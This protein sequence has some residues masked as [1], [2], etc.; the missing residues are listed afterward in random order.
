[1]RKV[2]YA[3]FG[4][5]RFGQSIVRTLVE[6]GQDVLACDI[7]KEVVNEVSTYA[8]HVIQIDV[9]EEA[10]LCAIGLSNFDVVLVCIGNLASAAMIILMAKEEGVEKV[11][12]KANSKREKVI[13][14]KIGADIV[15]LPEKEMGVRIATNLLNEHI[16]EAIDLS[17]RYCIAEIQPMVKWIGLSII[18]SNIRSVNKLNIVAIRRGDE[19]IVPPN[20]YEIINKYDIL[21]VVG[22]TDI[23]RKMKK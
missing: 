11:I 21:V 18:D 14:E 3:V 17:D 2:Q 19:I 7:D 9:N 4:L 6:N 10:S 8:N 1:M 20:P 15:V 5:G 23:L 13:F 12:T 16:I 22:E